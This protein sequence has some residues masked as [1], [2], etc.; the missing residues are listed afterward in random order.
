METKREPLGISGNRLLLPEKKRKRK[1][2]KKEGLTLLMVD[3]KFIF[4]YWSSKI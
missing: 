4:I 1:E 3:Q 2:I